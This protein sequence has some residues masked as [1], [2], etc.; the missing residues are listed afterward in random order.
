VAAVAAAAWRE[1][2]ATA[3]A[4]ADSAPPEAAEAKAAAWKAW[5]AAEEP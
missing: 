3:D 5:K 2:R 1:W 4:D